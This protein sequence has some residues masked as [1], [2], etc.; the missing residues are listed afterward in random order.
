M[1]DTLI[2]FLK[3]FLEKVIV[4]KSQHVEQLPACKELK[5]V[6]TFIQVSLVYKLML[7]SLK[8]QVCVGIFNPSGTLPTLFQWW[9]C[10]Q[11]WSH[12]GGGHMFY[13][14]LQKE[15]LKKKSSCLKP[16][17]LDP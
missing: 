9:F 11:E 3:D 16:E 6:S 4:E 13:I 17:S 5:H 8:F 15:I 10:D 14:D 1:F 12:P 7:N 2:V